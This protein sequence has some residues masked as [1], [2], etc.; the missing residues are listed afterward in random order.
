MWWWMP[1][2]KLPASLQIQL[3]DR[4]ECRFLT[5]SVPMPVRSTLTFDYDLGSLASLSL[6]RLM[7]QRKPSYTIHLIQI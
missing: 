5:L 1:Q 3:G 2:R 7:V 4:L 6:K